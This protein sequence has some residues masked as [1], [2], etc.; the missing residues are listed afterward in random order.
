MKATPEQ[1]RAGVD[2]LHR[3]TEHRSVKRDPQGAVAAVYEA[4][5]AE[6][7]VPAPALVA[8]EAKLEGTWK[9]GSVP[10]LEL[11]SLGGT[12]A[13]PVAPTAPRKRRRA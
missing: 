4:M 1:I 9:R 13:P 11:D 7:L 5:T 8:G 12:V 3:A 6:H 2:A 10:L